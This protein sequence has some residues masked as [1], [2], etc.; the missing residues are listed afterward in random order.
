MLVDFVGV[1]ST[2]TSDLPHGLPLYVNLKNTVLKP[3]EDD[4]ED[5]SKVKIGPKR[6]ILAFWSHKPE[7]VNKVEGFKFKTFKLK[8]KRKRLRESRRKLKRERQLKK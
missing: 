8:L 6:T 7:T 2:W 1:K 3:S 5:K 4:Q